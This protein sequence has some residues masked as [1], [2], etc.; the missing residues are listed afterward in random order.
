[1]W[2]LGV[3]GVSLISH[4]NKIKG[5]CLCLALS[6]VI[7]VP[8]LGYTTNE[9]SPL[10][11]F[12][13]IHECLVQCVSSPL[14]LRMLSIHVIFDLPLVRDPGVVPCI[15]CFSKLSDFFLQFLMV[16]R[17]YVNF[18]AF[19]DSRRFH[20]LSIPALSSTQSFVCSAVHDKH[21]I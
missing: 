7:L 14:N 20:F 3:G 19:S 5:H 9:L 2:V 12:F 10:D 17:K 21:S 13:R 11:S 4:H 6:S 8:W 1:M 15:I 16:C 18:L